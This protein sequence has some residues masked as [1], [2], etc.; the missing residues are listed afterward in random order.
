VRHVHFRRLVG[1]RVTRGVVDGLLSRALA[2]S[3]IGQR[4][5]RNGCA[6]DDEKRDCGMGEACH[7]RADSLAKSWSCRRGCAS[8]GTHEAMTCNMAIAASQAIAGR[9]VAIPAYRLTAAQHARSTPF[10]AIFRAATRYGS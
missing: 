7:K 1:I 6:A 3:R 8:R 4:L 2:A 5:L 10:V 9:R